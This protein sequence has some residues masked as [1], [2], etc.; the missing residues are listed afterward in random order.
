MIA[1]AGTVTPAGSGRLVKKFRAMSATRSGKGTTS[2]K[3]FRSCSTADLRRMAGQSLA[4]TC[5]V[6]YARAGASE[7]FLG[8]KQLAPTRPSPT[9]LP[10]RGWQSRLRGRTYLPTPTCLHSGQLRNVKKDQTQRK[11]WAALLVT[12]RSMLGLGLV[13]VATLT[14]SSGQRHSAPRANHPQHVPGPSVHRR[15]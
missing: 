8:L 10:T 1:P 3:R 2:V 9:Y 13:S 6:L 11:L 4:H 15:R 5:S 7:E 14:K 12:V